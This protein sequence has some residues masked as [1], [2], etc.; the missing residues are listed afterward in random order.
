MSYV[1]QELCGEIAD[2][3]QALAEKDLFIAQANRH[4]EELFAKVAQKDRELELA[5]FTIRECLEKI[6][7][8]DK[9]YQQLMRK[10]FRFAIALVGNIANKDEIEKEAIE[11]LDS[12]ESEAWKD[13]QK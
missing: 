4:K 3:K 11:F 9:V 1:I 13:Q 7:A 8:M 10:A 5:N 2:L 6:T 12:P